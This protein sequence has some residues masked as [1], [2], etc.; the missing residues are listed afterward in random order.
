MPATVPSTVRPFIS[1]PPVDD[2]LY[3]PIPMFLAESQRIATNSSFNADER[4]KARR[5]GFIEYVE[6]WCL[7]LDRLLN[8]EKNT[9]HVILLQL[10]LKLVLLHADRKESGSVDDFH[11]EF[12]SITSLAVSF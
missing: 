1:C 4:D 12:G 9:T 3:E 5:A 6:N 8:G 10:Y 2:S 11:T 7:A